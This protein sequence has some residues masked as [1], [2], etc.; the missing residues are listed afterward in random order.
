MVAGVADYP[1]M[2]PNELFDPPLDFTKIINMM[3]CRISIYSDDD[4][5][6]PKKITDH[7]ADVLQADSVLD[8]G[9]G[10]FAGQQG[11]AELPSA[12]EAVRRC[13]DSIR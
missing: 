10:H 4:R 9:K 11:L 7:L 1:L 8:P 13:L 6:V 3:S 2:R 5:S 12:L